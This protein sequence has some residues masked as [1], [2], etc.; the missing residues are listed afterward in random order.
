[1]DITALVRAR[2][3]YHFVCFSFLHFDDLI[4][5]HGNVEEGMQT[6][7]DFLDSAE[8]PPP[9]IRVFRPLAFVMTLGQR[10]TPNERAIR[11]SYL[12]LQIYFYGEAILLVARQIAKNNYVLGKVSNVRSVAFWLELTGGLLIIMGQ[13]GRQ[14]MDAIVSPL[15][16]PRAGRWLVEWRQFLFIFYFP[17]MGGLQGPVI[18]L[19]TVYG[20]DTNWWLLHKPL[21]TAVQLLILQLGIHKVF[22]P[23]YSWKYLAPLRKGYSVRTR[24]EFRAHVHDLF[25]ESLAPG[26]T[27]ASHEVAEAY[28]QKGVR[29]G[30]SRQVAVASPESAGGRHQR[31]SCCPPDARPTCPAGGGCPS[32]GQPASAA[33][34]R[35]VVQPA[36]LAGQT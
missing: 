1:M 22:V 8:P 4:L 31:T 6:V 17:F 23:P 3:V 2:W 20:F 33:G 24:K 29:K 10:F 14:Q 5:R 18:S 15:L 28:R 36:L 27:V 26:F 21:F 16:R 12:R 35:W 9:K 13:S 11:W 7:G 25:R 30:S 34:A 32:A 19:I